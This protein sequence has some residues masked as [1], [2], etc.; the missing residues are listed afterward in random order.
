MPKETII[1]CDG[2]GVVI[3][4]PLVPADPAPMVIYASYGEAN[5]DPRNS[6]PISNWDFKVFHSFDCFKDYDFTAWDEA[7]QKAEKQIEEAEA[8]AG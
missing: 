5:H 1:T 8:E 2:C 7:I 3:E 6:E 4:E